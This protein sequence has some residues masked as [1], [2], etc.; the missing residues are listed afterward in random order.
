MEFL[1]WCRS[2]CVSAEVLSVVE[3]RRFRPCGLAVVAALAQAAHAL[4]VVGVQT[5]FDELDAFDRPMVGYGAG[6]TAYAMVSSA[7]VRPVAGT[8]APRVPCQHAGA[9]E[10]MRFRRVWIAASCPALVFGFPAFV[11]QRA[12]GDQVWATGGGAYLV[13]QPPTS[14]RKRRD[15]LACHIGVCPL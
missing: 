14:A 1:F 5:C 10:A 3:A 15:W 13:H 2:L 6:G 8:D 11:A 12:G 9:C 4:R 7:S